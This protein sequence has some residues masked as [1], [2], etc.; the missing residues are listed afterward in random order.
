MRNPAEPL[1]LAHLRRLTAEL[2]RTSRL[3]QESYA[4]RRRLEAEVGSLRRRLERTL[5][6]L[7]LS[8][9]LVK[10]H[11]QGKREQR[12][13]AEMWKHRALTSTSPS[14]SRSTESQP[15]KP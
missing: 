15:W 7:T 8:R 5:I 14:P 9:K 10:N 3:L 4:E 13:R 6:R 12:N 11:Y 2:E 1:M